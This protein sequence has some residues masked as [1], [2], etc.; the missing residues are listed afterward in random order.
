MHKRIDNTTRITR[1]G[2]S[3]SKVQCTVPDD[4][5]TNIFDSITCCTSHKCNQATQF[6]PWF[7]LLIISLFTILIIIIN[8]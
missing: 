7:F 8:I 6:K 4:D 5:P 3:T 2:C 1:R